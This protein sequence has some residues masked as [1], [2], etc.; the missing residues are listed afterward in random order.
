MKTI[1]NIIEMLSIDNFD[2][3]NWTTKF[4]SYVVDLKGLEL[5]NSWKTIIETQHEEEYFLKL[6]KFLSHCLK[7]TKGAIKIYPYPDLIFNSMNKTT[8]DNIKVV[9][10][11]QDPYHN[12]IQVNGKLIPQAMGLSFSVPI[13]ISIPSSLKN[14]FQNLYNFGHIKKIPAHGNLENWALQGC[15]LLNTALTVQHGYPNSHAKFWEPLTDFLIEKISKELSNIVFVLWGSPALNK[16][17]FIDGKKHKI[18]ISSH[19]SG[20]SYSK[21]LRNYPAF[22]DFDHF[23]EINKYLTQ[24]KISTINWDFF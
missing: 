1:N 14:I 18:I 8:F 4:P 10:L 23:G 5:D 2:Y 22:K 6:N 19:P 13:G 16:F 12:S 3:N 17:K 24:K 20:L 21:P 15:L 11:G 7:S 9:I